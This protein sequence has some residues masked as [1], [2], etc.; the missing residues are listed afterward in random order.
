MYCIFVDNGLLR[1]GEFEQV[2]EQYKVLGLNVKGINAKDRFLDE[3]EGVSDPEAKRKI[4]GRVIID[5]FDDEAKKIDD[6]KWFAQGTINPDHI[7]SV[8][9]EDSPSQTIKSHHN[10][11]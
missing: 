5:V 4:I 8:R 10:V 1:K 3:L 2:L 9:V 6:P 11:G 7:E